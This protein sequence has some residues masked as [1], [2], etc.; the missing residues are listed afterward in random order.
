MSAIET[1]DLTKHYRQGDALVKA[2][3][4]V[5][6]RIESG[7]F[8]AVVGRSGSGKTTMLDLVGLL[9][10]PTAG[11]VHIDGQDT[12]ALG[13]SQRADLRAAK[14]GFIFQEYNLMPTMSALENVMLPLRYNRAKRSGGKERALQLLR[15]VDLEA[16]SRHRPTQLSGGEQ[17]RVAVARAL[18]NEP[19]I[20]L[21]DEP[22]GNLD[23]QLAD[24]L[25]QVLRRTNRDHG[26]TVVIVTHDV[27]LA[28]KTDR[29]I[30]LKDGVVIE[31]AP[32]DAPAREIQE[33][34][35]A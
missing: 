31:D 18:I 34:A 24:G 4:G 16:R 2:L 17:Q 9:L 30:R 1:F 32:V 27:D 23:T 8:V 5:S 25:M 12:G 14:I 15:E 26:V 28:G 11:S 33:P 22:T 20:I 29:I 10:R 7:E 6:L 21:G 19:R 13:D 3:D 35:P